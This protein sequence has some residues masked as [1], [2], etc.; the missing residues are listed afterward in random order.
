MGHESDEPE[1]GIDM[2]PGRASRRSGK[3]GESPRGGLRA[4]GRPAPAEGS[5]P[6]SVKTRVV[7]A[8]DHPIFGASLAQLIGTSLEFSVTA[9]CRD[10]AETI[11]ALNEAESDLLILDVGMPDVKFFDFLAEI[12]HGFPQLRVLVLS[13]LPEERYAVRALREGAAGCIMKTAA[14]DELLRAM[15]AV[16]AGERYITPSVAELLADALATPSQDPG[17]ILTRRE[18]EVFRR[19]GGGLSTKEVAEGLRISPKTVA[20]YRAR[21][22]EKLGIHSPAELI[23]RAIEWEDREG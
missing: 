16:A 14:P 5:H 10:G 20:T 8:D 11:A 22:Y 3:G 7:I 4:S 12:R 1:I 17:R 18:L 23:R 15:Q 9:V 2:E 6:T 13:G 21:I 19:M